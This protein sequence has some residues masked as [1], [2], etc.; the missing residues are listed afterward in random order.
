MP[1]AVLLSGNWYNKILKGKILR[2]RGWVLDDDLCNFI[3]DYLLNDEKLLVS[4]FALILNLKN[5]YQHFKKLSHFYENA[6]QKDPSLIFKANDFT[7]I[8]RDLLLDILIK[9]NHSLKP[10][11]LWDKL[12]E[13]AISQSNKL[14]SDITKWTANNVSM[15]GNLIQQFIPHINFKEIDQNDFTLK[16]KPFKSIF[17]DKFYIEILEYY[18][19]DNTKDSEFSK[20]LG[21]ILRFVEKEEMVLDFNEDMNYLYKFKLL[22]RGSTNGFNCK[23]F[24]EC[25]DNKGPTITIAKLKNTDMVVGGYNPYN[26]NDDFLVNNWNDNWNVNYQI[27]N[28]LSLTSAKSPFTFHFY[29]NDLSNLPIIQL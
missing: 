29:L 25:C 16:I 9:N 21:N 26:W 28:N 12:V 2:Q 3:E 4:N 22:I 5:K 27:N 6:S 24:H 17:D 18:N 7:T 1:C 14:P 10:I 20:I 23:T 11:E 13:W 8:K 15:F 19:F